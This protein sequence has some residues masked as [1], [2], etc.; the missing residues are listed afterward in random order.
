MQFEHLVPLLVQAVATI[1]MVPRKGALLFPNRR[2]PRLP[3]TGY[4]LSAL[5]ARVGFA[6][7]YRSA[8]GRLFRQL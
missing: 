1:K 7:T 4:A 5:V 3:M 2:T 8:G 6:V